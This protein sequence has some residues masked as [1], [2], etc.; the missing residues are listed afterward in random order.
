MAIDRLSQ[1]KESGDWSGE[2]R[3]GEFKGLETFWGRDRIKN[4]R[5]PPQ[6][7]SPVEALFISRNFSENS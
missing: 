4:A 2:M 6:A 3:K 5:I 7:E 1:S